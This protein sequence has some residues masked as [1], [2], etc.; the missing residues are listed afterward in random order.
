MVTLSPL[1]Y[2]EVYVG[3]SFGNFFERKKLENHNSIRIPKFWILLESLKTF[4]KTFWKYRNSDG[5]TILRD[6]YW[7]IE[8]AKEFRMPNTQNISNKFRLNINLVQ[9]L[10][11]NSFWKKLLKLKLEKSAEN[12]FQILNHTDFARLLKLLIS[13]R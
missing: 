9:K 2:L 11:G 8:I 10:L 3:N 1:L 5:D 6:F 13:E 7:I 4:Q 12:I